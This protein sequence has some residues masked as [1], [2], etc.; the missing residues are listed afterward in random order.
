MRGSPVPPPDGPTRHDSCDLAA[1]PTPFAI[2]RGPF[3]TAPRRPMQARTRILVGLG[4]LLLGASCAAEAP[5]NPAADDPIPEELLGALDAAAKTKA[6]PSMAVLPSGE[7]LA[8]FAERTGLRTREVQRPELRLSDVENAA[9][10][11]ESETSLI[12]AMVLNA[13][14][15]TAD[16][17]F[18]A[19]GS[20]RPAQAGIAYSFGSKTTTDRCFPPAGACGPETDKAC[21]TASPLAWQQAVFGVDCSGLI[22]LAA[23]AAGIPVGKVNSG[24]LLTPKTW[25]DALA[26]ISK[27][28]TAVAIDIDATGTNLRAGDIIGTYLPGAG[29]HIGIVDHVDAEGVW[30]LESHGTSGKPDS[31]RNLTLAQNCALNNDRTR[32]G[33]LIVNYISGKGSIPSFLSVLKSNGKTPALRGV[34]IQSKCRAQRLIR[35]SPPSPRCPFD[36]TGRVVDTTTGLTWMELPWRNGG[37]ATAAS[38]CASKGMRLP[39]SGEAREIMV[40]FEASIIEGKG[41]GWGECPFNCTTIS[42]TLV[43]EKC[44]DGRFSFAHC[45]I[46]PGT[47]SNTSDMRCSGSFESTCQLPTELDTKM[48]VHCVS[49]EPK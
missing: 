21:P 30:V 19:Q 42:D 36:G 37:S 12:A 5:S 23:T 32:R 28:L 2:G 14:S 1:M 43:S 33:A 49:G 3:G 22:Y 18:P 31:K 46:N 26:K 9:I 17:A 16:R 13:H 35:I 11:P 39:T 15:L 10:D 6:D 47:T 24:T 40:A 8:A 27:R 25:A 7:T 44:E 34:R 38:D 41:S 20:Q 45:S 4:T 48:V 29:G